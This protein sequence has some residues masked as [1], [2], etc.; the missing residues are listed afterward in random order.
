[1]LDIWWNIS[2]NNIGCCVVSHYRMF[3][4]PGFWAPFTK[5][6]SPWRRLWPN[7]DVSRL[8]WTL[9]KAHS[10]VV[11]LSFETFWRYI[12]CLNTPYSIQ[13]DCGWVRYKIIISYY[14]QLIRYGLNRLLFS[15]TFINTAQLLLI[16]YHISAI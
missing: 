2:I 13:I 11:K 1:M 9:T 8:T 3:V 6:R 10:S 5:R 15:R 16:M 12:S 4:I 7:H 14:I